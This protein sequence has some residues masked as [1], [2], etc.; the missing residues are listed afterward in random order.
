MKFRV[1]KKNNSK[2]VLINYRNGVTH[3]D[4]DEIKQEVT[5]T[6]NG[7]THTKRLIAI[8]EINYK[9]GLIVTEYE[10]RKRK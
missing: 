7:I 3:G 5:F 8:N 9:T 1:V 6:F 4:L 2:R 10:E